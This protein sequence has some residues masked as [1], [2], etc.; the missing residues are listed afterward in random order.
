MREALQ[1]AI[2]IYNSTILKW[3][4]FREYMSRRIISTPPTNTVMYNAEK[5]IYNILERGGKVDIVSVLEATIK[6]AAED[7]RKRLIELGKPK[8]PLGSAKFG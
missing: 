5:R 8:E 1:E 4:R 6:K 2:S 3:E 7:N